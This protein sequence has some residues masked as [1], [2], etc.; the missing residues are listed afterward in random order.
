V[1]M[2]TSTGLPADRGRALSVG[3]SKGPHANEGRRSEPHL[4]ELE[5]I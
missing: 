2:T 5:A 3:E 1:L 4:R